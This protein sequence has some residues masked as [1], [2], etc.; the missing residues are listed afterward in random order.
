MDEIQPGGE[1]SQESFPSH[2]AHYSTSP[3]EWYTKDNRRLKTTLAVASGLLFLAVILVVY[4]S[5]ALVGTGLVAPA[6]RLRHRVVREGD[7]SARVAVVPVSG[8]IYSGEGGRGPR[9][10]TAGWVVEAL[11][12]A[13]KDRAVKTVILEVDSPGG[14]ITGSDLIHH[15]VEKLRRQGTKVVALLRGLATSGGYY[16]SASADRIVAYPTGITGSIGTIFQSIHVD[17]LLAKLGVSAVV[18]TSGEFKDMASPFR[19]PTEKE[20]AMLQSIVD[21]AFERFVGVVARGRKMS[22]EKVKEIADGRILTA[23]QAKAAGLVDSLGYFEKAVEAAEEV[24]GISGA[25]VVRYRRAPSLLDI[26]TMDS[27]SRGPAAE[28]A[29]LLSRLGPMYL[30]DNLP[31]GGYIWRAGAGER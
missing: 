25:E 11:T 28:L 30:A 26:L 31:A 9:A 10:G 17:G 13:G 23:E 15:E 18:V 27:N 21:E 1:R 12:A 14:T 5:L 16:V 19:A 29:R 2:P 3:K 20:R 6:G 7:P 4:L 24:A 22:R 8:L